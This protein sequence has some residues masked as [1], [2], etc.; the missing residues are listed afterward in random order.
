M[1]S[2]IITI[3]VN[4][5]GVFGDE[6]LFSVGQSALISA[7][8]VMSQA[9]DHKY[10]ITCDVYMHKEPHLKEPTEN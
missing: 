4:E 10:N 8:Q 1:S 2:T 5:D 7:L 3:N 6:E 9:V